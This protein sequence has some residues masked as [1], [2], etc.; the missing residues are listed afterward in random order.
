M[1]TSLQRNTGALVDIV[2]QDTA[3]FRANILEGDIVIQIADKPVET[4]QQL[5]DLL[6]S[7]AGQKVI[8]KVIRGSQ[9]LD[10]NVQLAEPLKENYRIR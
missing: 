4:V 8:L 6:P 10:V 7:Y 9:T 2:I 5:V 3:A 1:R